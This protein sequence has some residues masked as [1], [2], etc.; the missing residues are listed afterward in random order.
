MA[1]DN[2]RTPPADAPD[3]ARKQEGQL[4]QPVAPAELLDDD[5]AAQKCRSVGVVAVEH[6]HSLLGP[7]AGQVTGGMEELALRSADTEAV[8]HM[9][10]TEHGSHYVTLPSAIQ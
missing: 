8:D 6:E 2:V 10:D 1:G 9:Q 4:T 7:A 5:P 3:D